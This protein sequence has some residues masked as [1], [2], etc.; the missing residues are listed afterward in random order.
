MKSQTV[1]K[2][3]LV[4]SM[5]SAAGNMLSYLIMALFLPALTNIYATHPDLMPAEF[6]TLWESMA[7]VPRPYYAGMAALSALSFAGCILMWKLHRGGFHCY[8]IAQ[9]M[10]LAL[11]LLFLGKGYL[12]IGDM[13]FT[14]LFLLMYWMLLKSLGVFAPKESLVSEE[15][16]NEND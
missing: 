16:K 9:L 2:I 10:M 13:M 15:P 8:A 4:L 7:A 14:A 5:I 12:G 1:L 3:L 11:P 6:Y